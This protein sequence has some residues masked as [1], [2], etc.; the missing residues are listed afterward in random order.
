MEVY[1]VMRRDDN[2]CSF[3]FSPHEFVLSVC[4]SK[5]KAKEHIERYADSYF[6][7]CSQD[8]KPWKYTNNNGWR[9]NVEWRAQ[10]GCL[11]NAA[12]Y[13]CK[14]ELNEYEES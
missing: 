8:F 1:V 6:N 11:N 7:N 12:F 14:Y 5:E 9:I 10:D 4:D 3:E 2:D 13:C